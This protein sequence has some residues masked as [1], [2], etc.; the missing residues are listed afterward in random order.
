MSAPSSS[1]RVAVPLRKGGLVKVMLSALLVVVGCVWLRAPRDSGAPTTP[2]LE[3]LSVIGILFFGSAALFAARKVL[4]GTPALVLDSEGMLDN[5]SA[6]AVGRVRWA[7]ITQIRVIE[8]ARQRYLSVSVRDPEP[9]LEKGGP[10]R[11][12]LNRANFLKVGA[13][14]NIKA[15]TLAMPFDRVVE[16]VSDF[17]RMYGRPA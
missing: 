8:V 2:A 3:I 7:E 11:R 5:S 1:D 13:P 12:K 6:L 14:I 15:T 9:F 17:Y 16:R 4:D 10:L